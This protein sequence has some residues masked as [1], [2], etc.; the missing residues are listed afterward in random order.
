MVRVKG[1]SWHESNIFT[2]IDNNKHSGYCNVDNNTIACLSSSKEILFRDKTNGSI[3]KRV[4]LETDNYSDLS[5][6]LQFCA[7]YFYNNCFYAITETAI[8]KISNLDTNETPIINRI[9][10]YQDS[11]TRKPGD[12]KLINNCL[13]FYDYSSINQSL[14]RS[15]TQHFL[16]GL[17]LK[18]VLPK[19]PIKSDYN[20]K[21]STQPDYIKNKPIT[22]EYVNNY[23]AQGISIPVAQQ[24]NES[25]FNIKEQYIDL[26]VGEKYNVDLKVASTIDGSTNI[27]SFEVDC[28]DMSG[29]WGQNAECPGIVIAPQV[30]LMVYPQLTYATISD[31]L[32]FMY[33]NNTNSMA[34]DASVSISCVGELNEV[35][36]ANPNLE[37]EINVYQPSLES[38]IET[39]YVEALQ[40]DWTET[41]STKVGYIKNKPCER[42]DFN[43]NELESLGLATTAANFKTESNYESL[44]IIGIIGLGV[45]SGDNV[46][47]V[48]NIPYEAIVFNN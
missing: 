18:K 36:A 3:I 31:G 9:S 29:F 13:M 25:A 39:P 27:H 28:V 38:H 33:T 23:L 41:D 11:Y 15:Y 16:T 37:I 22:A 10:L 47:N 35:G 26:K 43:L 45:E 46:I 42:Y 4:S 6:N 8:Y 7:T 12:I 14:T 21:D 44:E 48:T 19:T 30:M 24:M 20:Q 2:N 34:Y 1:K 5:S 32:V 17:P 40:A